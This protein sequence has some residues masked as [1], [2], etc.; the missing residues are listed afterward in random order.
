ML[1]EISIACKTIELISNSFSSTQQQWDTAAVVTPVL[2]TPPSHS[3]LLFVTGARSEVFKYQHPDL[4]RAGNLMAPGSS[5]I[6]ES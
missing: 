5:L 4:E 3:G 2:P 1:S 6:Q